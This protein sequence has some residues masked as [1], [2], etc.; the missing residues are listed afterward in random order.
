M[1]ADPRECMLKKHERWNTVTRSIRKRSVNAG[2]PTGPELCVGHVVLDSIGPAEDEEYRIRTSSEEEKKPIE[3]FAKG[4][5]LS[6]EC[7]AL[8]GGFVATAVVGD[9]R[10]LWASYVSRPVVQRC[11]CPLHDRIGNT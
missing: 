6:L 8:N 11:S 2:S 7:S 9:H 5:G 1:A 3:T 4:S 10:Q